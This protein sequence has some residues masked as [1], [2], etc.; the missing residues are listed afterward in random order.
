VIRRHAF[1]ALTTTL[2]IVAVVL[3]AANLAKAAVYVTLLA[4]VSAFVG[5]AVTASHHRT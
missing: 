1:T 2:L 3:L 5:A 4:I